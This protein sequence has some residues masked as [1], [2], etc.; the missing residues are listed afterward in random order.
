MYSALTVVRN[1]Q[2]GLREQGTGGRLECPLV[3]TGPR[4][5]R[6]ASPEGPSSRS[7]RRALLRRVAFIGVAFSVYTA[8]GHHHIGLTGGP[9][10]G[11]L[12]AGLI[13]GQTP[14]TDLTPYHPQRFD[15]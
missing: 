2:L 11:R 9:K 14:N 10:T 1:V 5:I 15:G 12:I 6:R 3:R 8:F 7:M 4:P 13:T